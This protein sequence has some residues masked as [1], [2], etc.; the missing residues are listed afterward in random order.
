MMSF[1]EMLELRTLGSELHILCRTAREE[2][3]C[4]TVMY[5]CSFLPKLVHKTDG[6][7]LPQ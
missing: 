7:S 5:G 2:N 1:T 4:S 3:P 6:V